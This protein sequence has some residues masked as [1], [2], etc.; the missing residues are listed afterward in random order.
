MNKKIYDDLANNKIKFYSYD[1]EQENTFYPLDGSLILSGSFNPLHDGHINLLKA[2]LNEYNKIPLYEISITNVD[3]SKIVFNDLLNR[4]S[5]FKSLGKLVITNSP[6]FEEKS[7]IFTK[8][9]FVIG[10][11]T[12]ERLVDNKY[13]KNGFKESLNIIERNNC[14]FL[15]SG[16]LIKNKYYKPA[17]INFDGYDH[18]FDTLS[19]EKFR[20][21]ISST[22]LRNLS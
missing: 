14:S 15:V 3:K 6:T 8:S 11:D 13:Y 18:L 21:D 7:K 22:E 12:A 17:N 2:S 1:N 19:E 5:Q 20:L 10:Y 16:R 9:I 4:I